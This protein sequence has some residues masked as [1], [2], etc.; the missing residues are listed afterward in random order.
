MS[1][2][3]ES[4]RAQSVSWAAPI[5]VGKVTLTVRDL[6]KVRDYYN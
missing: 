2:S 1:P 5:R 3:V 6:P 4:T